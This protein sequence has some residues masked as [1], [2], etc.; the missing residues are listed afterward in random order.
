[1]FSFSVR[2]LVIKA[3]RILAE[4]RIYDLF[5]ETKVFVGNYPFIAVILACMT[6]AC[7]I[8]VLIFVAFAA[9]TIFFTFSGFI[10]IEGKFLL[11]LNDYS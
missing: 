3:S 2:L 9:I 1:M 6:I 10:V 11:R 8:P 4:L 5:D 7:G